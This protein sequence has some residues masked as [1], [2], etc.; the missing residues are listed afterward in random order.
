MNFASFIKEIGRGAQGARDLGEDEARQLFG[1]ML[2]GG[3]PEL[4][5]GAVVLSLRNKTESVGELLGF[6]RASD[7]RLVRLKAP[8]G[9]ARPVVIPT[10]NGARHQANLLPLLV[11]L[12]KRLGV[13]V[14]IHG[15]LDGNGRVATA[16][17]LRE[18]GILPCATAAQ[19]Q[20][21]L[22]S[23]GVAHTRGA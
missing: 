14:L 8:T 20:R 7:D 10:Y 4:E 11:L 13:P 21:T 22:D 16:Y 3:V 18:L 2:D 12:L 5:L 19:A 6:Q 9:E 17:I 15:C 23:E 1:A